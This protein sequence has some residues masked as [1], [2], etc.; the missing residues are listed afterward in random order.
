VTDI[1]RV[2][3]NVSAIDPCTVEYVNGHRFDLRVDNLRLID[4]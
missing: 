4:V 1:G 2:V 3:L